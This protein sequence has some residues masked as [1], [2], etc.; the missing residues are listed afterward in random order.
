MK[1]TYKQTKVKEVASITKA[2]GRLKSL[3]NLYDY[4]K[5]Q[6]K[7]KTTIA[8]LEKEMEYWRVQV[9]RLTQFKKHIKTVHALAEQERK[10]MFLHKK[11]NTEAEATHKVIEVDGDGDSLFEGTKRE[12]QAYID[13]TGLITL[14]IENV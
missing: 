6:P 3:T 1:T 4:V 13:G 10:K 5:D 7:K 12:C 8:K 9:D 14:T 2:K 11:V